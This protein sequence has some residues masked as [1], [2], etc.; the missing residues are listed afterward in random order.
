MIIENSTV[1]KSQTIKCS[2]QQPTTQK[3]KKLEKNG[4]T[5]LFEAKRERKIRGE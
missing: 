2:T 4:K 3:K 5:N 1:D